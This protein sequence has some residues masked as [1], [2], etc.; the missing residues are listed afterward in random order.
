LENNQI[1]LDFLG[2]DSMRYQNTVE[3]DAQVWQNFKVFVS[4]KE[5]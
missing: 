2:K 4:N 3:V 1:K 5:P